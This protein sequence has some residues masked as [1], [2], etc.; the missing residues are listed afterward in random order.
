MSAHSSSTQSSRPHSNH[1][2]CVSD[3]EPICEDVRALAARLDR[4]RVAVQ[5][6]QWHAMPHAL[7]CVAPFLPEANQAL[8]Q[9]AMF[10]RRCYATRKRNTAAIATA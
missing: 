3:S 6:A 9:A 1:A 5:L 7:P 8:R 4:A 10:V 2:V